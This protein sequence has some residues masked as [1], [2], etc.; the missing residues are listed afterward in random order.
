V[1]GFVA[2]IAHTPRTAAVSTAELLLGQAP[3]DADRE[4]VIATWV[5]MVMGLVAKSDVEDQS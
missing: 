2:I 5:E 3:V 4:E 1:S